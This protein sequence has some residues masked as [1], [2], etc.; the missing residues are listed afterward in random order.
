MRFSIFPSWKLQ[1]HNKI[2]AK[3]AEIFGRYLYVF[4]PRSLLYQ[5]F[6]KLF[7]REAN[8]PQKWPINPNDNCQFDNCQMGMEFS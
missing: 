6:A 7:R 8:W 2:S 5:V 4:S 3:L 1:K